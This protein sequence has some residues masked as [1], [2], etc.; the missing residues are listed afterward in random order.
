MAAGDDKAA[1]K[2]ILD[3]A[4]RQYRAVTKTYEVLLNHGRGVARDCAES[5]EWLRNASGAGDA[6]AATN[7]ATSCFMG[8]GVDLN[9]APR[10]QWIQIGVESNDPKALFTLD[11]GYAVSPLWYRT[12]EVKRE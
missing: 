4:N 12:I 9:S 5:F 3:A 10:T 7:L 8:V 11:A 2:W 6:S 1:V